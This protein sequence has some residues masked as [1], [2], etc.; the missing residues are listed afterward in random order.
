[1]DS[2]LFSLAY[3]TDEHNLRP[4]SRIIQK[5]SVRSSSP[6]RYVCENALCTS[7]QQVCVK[8]RV[9]EFA[10]SCTYKCM[11]SM[12]VCNVYVYAHIMYRIFIR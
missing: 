10:Y 5:G 1:M 11:Y 2:G 12:C 7:V 8:V 4:P 9:Y 3:G 6:G